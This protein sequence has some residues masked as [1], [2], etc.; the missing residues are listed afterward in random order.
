MQAASAV[1]VPASKEEPAAHVGVDQGTHAPAAL[2][3]TVAFDQKPAGQAAQLVSAVALQ[4]TVYWP[5]T[6][7][8]A[9]QAVHEADCVPAML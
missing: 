7:E 8:L 4:A 3:A 5:A 1:A 2:V 9:E 6:H